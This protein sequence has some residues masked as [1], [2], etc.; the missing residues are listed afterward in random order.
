MHGSNRRLDEWPPVCAFPKCQSFL[1]IYRVH[2][3]Y[4]KILLGRDDIR[5]T[6]IKN[7][8]D[9]HSK[10]FTTSSSQ[11]N[12]VSRKVMDTSL[13]QHGIIFNFRPAERRTISRDDD[14]FGYKLENT[15]FKKE[16]PRQLLTFA[17]S[18]GL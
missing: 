17:A 18:Q 8:H 15:L 10:V 6:L 9:S 1:V 13:A 7:R 4:S 5:I 2:N 14:K 3:I 12:I 11:I 16:P